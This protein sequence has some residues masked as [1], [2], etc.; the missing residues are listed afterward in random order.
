M[1]EYRARILEV[2]HADFTPLVFTCAG[3]I[4]PQSQMMLKRLAERISEKQG[5]NYSQV[6]GWLRAK[7]NF[8]ILKTTIL[9]IRA[10]RERRFKDETNIALAVSS[11][12]MDY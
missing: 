11:T 10:T 12:K 3:G 1:R 2:E 9:C 7:I 6:A 8:S 4:A 5:L